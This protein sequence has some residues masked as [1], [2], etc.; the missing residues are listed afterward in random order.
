[1]V[2]ALARLPDNSLLSLRA[3]SEESTISFLFLQKIARKLRKAGIITSVK[4]AFGGYTLRASAGDISMYQIL[5]AICGPLGFVECLKDNQ[6]CPQAKGCLSR[7][8]FAR[9]NTE[10]MASLSHLSVADM[11]EELSIQ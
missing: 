9:I 2:M 5:E 8:V 4:G 1:L 7:S 10:M 6:T 11:L 3:F